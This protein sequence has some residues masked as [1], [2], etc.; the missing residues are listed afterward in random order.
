MVTNISVFETVNVSSVSLSNTSLAMTEGDETT[1]TATVQP[2]NASNKTL[3]WKSDNPNVVSVDNDGLVIAKAPG[4]AT[5][6]VSAADGSGVSATCSVTVSAAIINVTGISLSSTSLSMVEGNTVSLTSSVTPSNATNKSVIWTSS[7]TNVAKVNDSGLVTAISEG[8]AT[9]TA[10][11]ADGSGVSA[12]CKVYVESAIVYVSSISLSNTSASLTEGDTKYLTYT[13]SPSNAT[14]KE[15][16]WSS[17]NTNVASVDAF[18]MISARSVGSATITATS[19]DGSGVKA[20]CYVSVQAATVYVSSITLSSSS[21]SMTEGDTQYL[22]ASVYPSNATNK[23]VTW[24][25]SNTS[26]ATVNSI[27]YGIC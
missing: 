6:T 18:G 16:T 10:T 24:S 3:V 15:V 19:N 5:I 8:S 23:S 12:S 25:S 2:S 11:A 13:I 7:N 22:S 14:N 27:W 1:L 26:V 9:I 21:L 20:T 4:T 17:S